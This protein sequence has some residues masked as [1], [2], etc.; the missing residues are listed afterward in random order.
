MSKNTP[1]NVTLR[2]FGGTCFPVEPTTAERIVTRVGNYLPHVATLSTCRNAARSSLQ[3]CRF[4]APPQGA[5]RGTADGPAAA[6][7]LVTRRRSTATSHEVVTRGESTSGTQRPASRFSTWAKPLR[8]CPL[9]SGDVSPPRRSWSD[10]FRGRRTS[11]DGRGW[12]RTHT[13]FPGGGTAWR[14]GP[15]SRSPARGSAPRSGRFFLLAC[16]LS[17]GQQGCRARPAATC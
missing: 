9:W 4:S 17:S 3:R 5:H 13:P 11:A 6:P 12:G 10:F 1:S 7:S 16:S 14:G 2:K 8:R 15:R